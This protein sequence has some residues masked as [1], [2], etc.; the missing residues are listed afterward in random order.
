VFWK[1]LRKYVSWNK[2]SQLD[3]AASDGMNLK[4]VLTST[5]IIH[6]SG[7]I[8]LILHTHKVGFWQGP[9]DP[10]TGSLRV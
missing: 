9:P 4:E 1:C 10:F 5:Q 2:E 7:V 3:F 8:G 6:R